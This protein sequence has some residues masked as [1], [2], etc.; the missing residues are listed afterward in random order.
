MDGIWK[1]CPKAGGP[2]PFPGFNGNFDLMTC[3]SIRYI[4]ISIK[5]FFW[6][7]SAGELI[8]PSYHELCSTG[9]VSLS[10]QCSNSCNFN[11]DCVSGECH[12]FLGFHGHDCSKSELQDPFLL[13][14]LDM[15]KIKP[16]I[17]NLFCAN[18]LI[19]FNKLM[20]FS[21]HLCCMIFRILP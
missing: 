2:V 11:G 15:C 19:L 16:G 20:L 6:C 10:G 14:H 1:V 3:L 4:S 17:W 9:P 21:V 13:H 8:C 7:L 12:C 18:H 5:N